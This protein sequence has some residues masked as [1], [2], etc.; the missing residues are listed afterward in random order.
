MPIL[1][2]FKVTTEND[3][4][5]IQYSCE[6][7][8]QIPKVHRI[9]WKKNGQ[10]LDRQTLKYIGGSLHDTYLKIASPIYED[11]GTYSCT[12]TNAMGSV[13]RDVMLGN[14]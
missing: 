6:P 4:I 12:V 9:E 13:C 14:I 10:P 7:S 11:R 1:S 3:G 2:N 8:R 5:I